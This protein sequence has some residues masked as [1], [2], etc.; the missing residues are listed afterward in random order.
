MDVSAERRAEA[1]PRY[2]CTRAFCTFC[3][4]NSYDENVVELAKNKQWH[5]HHCTGY[6]LC[7]RCL[8]ADHCTQAR[9]Y[10]LSVGGDFSELKDSK[11]LFD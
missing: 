5:C 1:T 10:L 6:C 2:A 8:R 9:A 11:S 4:R 3:L 7:T